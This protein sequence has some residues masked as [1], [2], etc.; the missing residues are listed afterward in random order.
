MDWN[1]GEKAAGAA[2][3]APK[4]AWRVQGGEDSGEDAA[5][6]DTDDT[7]S[8]G[9]D[10]MPV[11][12]SAIESITVENSTCQIGSSLHVYGPLNVHCE[13]FRVSADGAD[14]I[15][16]QCSQIENSVP[17]ARDLTLPNTPDA[18]GPANPCETD[19]ALCAEV[20]KSR[21]PL[22]LLLLPPCVFLVVVWGVGLTVA[23][24]ADADLLADDV[25]GDADVPCSTKPPAAA[26]PVLLPDGVGFVPRAAWGARTPRG[27]PEVLKTPV[28]TVIVHHSGTASCTNF[29]M[30]CERV[31]TMQQYNMDGRHFDDIAYNFLVGDDGRVYEGRGWDVV[32]D[33]LDPTVRQWHREAL[34]V[35]VIGTFTADLPSA[36]QRQQLY[37]FLRLGVKLG[38]IKTQ[39]RLVG[40]CQLARTPSPGLRFMHVLKNWYHWWDN[41]ADWG[42]LCDPAAQLNL[43]HSSPFQGAK[44]NQ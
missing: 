36:E 7:A 40:A 22:L 20:P 13:K 44:F 12:C 21:K 34:G 35:A 8:T 17:S 1:D 14:G 37:K 25:P 39:Y 26:S 31:F 9:A 3:V 24:K 32:G 6:V 30:C 15:A 42:D 11:P 28:N 41:G 18:T 38:K 5:S 10:A 4:C 2:V 23:L 16:K 19:G 33:A 29:K 43:D 27:A